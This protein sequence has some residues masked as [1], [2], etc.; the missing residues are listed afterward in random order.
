MFDIKNKID[1]S[2]NGIVSLFHLSTVCKQIYKFR[3]FPCLFIDK[4]N[5]DEE[6]ISRSQNL[7][8]LDV[9]VG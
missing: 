7:F 6:Y 1:H 4:K 8:T 9:Y 5:V 3:V 2:S